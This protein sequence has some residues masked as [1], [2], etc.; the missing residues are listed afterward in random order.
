MLAAGY[1]NDL[2]HLLLALTAK[3]GGRAARGGGGCGKKRTGESNL[4]RRRSCGLSPQDFLL[5]GQL[6]EFYSLAVTFELGDL[7]SCGLK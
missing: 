1:V 2:Y 6:E 3:S 5:F 4:R 7:D